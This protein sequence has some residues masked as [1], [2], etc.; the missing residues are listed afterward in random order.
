MAHKMYGLKVRLCS[1]RNAKH[2]MKDAWPLFIS[3]AMAKVLSGFGVTVLGTLASSSAVGIYSAIYKIPYTMALFFNPIS[4]AVYP[5]VSVAF[6]S[7]KENGYKRVKKIASPVITLFV[8]AAIVIAIFNHPIVWIL[9]G[10]EYVSSS[11][12]LIPLSMWFVLSIINNFLGIQ[13]L[14]ASGHQK[15]YSKAFTISAICSIAMYIVLGKIWGIFGI[16]FSTFLAELI[17]TILLIF[18]VRKK[19]L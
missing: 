1:L 11:L 10:N 4:Q 18:N 3:Q 13:I 7:S 15:Q 14:V 8:G 17:L 12:I 16:A 9:F 2:A 5:D 19:D 6:N